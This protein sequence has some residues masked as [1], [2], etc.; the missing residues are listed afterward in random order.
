MSEVQR[1]LFRQD[2]PELL[3]GIFL[4]EPSKL[5][6]RLFK[7][8]VRFFMELPP[9]FGA[10]AV[11]KSLRGKGKNHVA[12]K[13]EEYGMADSKTYSEKLIHT[14]AWRTQQFLK[15]QLCPF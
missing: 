13:F 15:L 8:T 7:A 5:D 9:S 2:I 1:T 6:F 11:I 12:N 3:K 14:L 10:T 4:R